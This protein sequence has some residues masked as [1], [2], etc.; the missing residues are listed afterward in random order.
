M[1]DQ[2]AR[3]ARLLLVRRDQRAVIVNGCTGAKP[4]DQAEAAPFSRRR[5]QDS[6]TLPT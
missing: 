2:Q 6:G 3:D 1:G 5:V 4:A